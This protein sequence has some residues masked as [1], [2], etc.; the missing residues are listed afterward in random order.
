MEDDGEVG[1][2]L[3]IISRNRTKN[4]TNTSEIAKMATK[5]GYEVVVAEA[6]GNVQRF[7]QIV[8]SCDVMMGIHGVDLA[9][10][11]FLLENAILIQIIPI[12]RV[13]WL[14]KIAFGEP[15][16]DMNIRYLDYK[17]QREE[18]SLI[19]QYSSEH[20]VLNNSS[21]I[22]KKRWMAFKAVYLDKQDVNLD[23]NRVFCYR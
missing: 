16:K 23:I 19:Q 15:F 4:F 11:V 7:A 1:P 8:N 6:D 9:N 18:S 20:E 14:A 22:W 12:G 3:L 5:L 2:R 10:M 21:S 13:G 17:I